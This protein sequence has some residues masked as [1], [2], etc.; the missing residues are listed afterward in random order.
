MKAAIKCSFNVTYERADREGLYG[1]LLTL[2]SLNS[3]LF[4]VW[5][6]V[7]VVNLSRERFTADYV[8]TSLS[9]NT[10]MIQSQ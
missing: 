1:I 3:F 10:F 2:A 5:C 7:L 9:V 8:T 6:T 4:A